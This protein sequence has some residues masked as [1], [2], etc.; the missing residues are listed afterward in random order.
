MKVN[1]QTRLLLGIISIST[2]PLKQ[3]YSEYDNSNVTAVLGTN[4]NMHSV[5]SKVSTEKME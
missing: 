1:E 4:Y 2:C 5:N 3:C